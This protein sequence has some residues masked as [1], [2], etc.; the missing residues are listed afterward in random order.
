MVDGCYA[1]MFAKREALQAIRILMKT[2]FAVRRYKLMIAKSRSE[3]VVQMQFGIIDAE[4]NALDPLVFDRSADGFN[5]TMKEFPA[6]S[7]SIDQTRAV[8]HSGNLDAVRRGA[9][10]NHVVAD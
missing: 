10:V 1:S 7:P 8:K 4:I 9:I 2:G 6:R 3:C 5:Q